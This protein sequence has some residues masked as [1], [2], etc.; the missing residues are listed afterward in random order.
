MKD[1]VNKLR[2]YFYLFVVLLVLGFLI[3]YA[4]KSSNDDKNLT[5]SVAF[6]DEVNIAPWPPD[7]V[8]HIRELEE[9]HPSP[10]R[11][12]DESEDDFKKRKQFEDDS[13]NI[14]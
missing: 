11:C 6:N 14:S 5:C 12:K 2:T 9:P 13:R 4:F 3:F 8:P 1:N 10:K 7:L